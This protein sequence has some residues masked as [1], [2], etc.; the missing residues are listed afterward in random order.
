MAASHERDAYRVGERNLFA[1]FVVNGY[2]RGYRCVL[3]VDKHIVEANGGFRLVELCNLAGKTHTRGRIDRFIQEH[4]VGAGHEAGVV[5]DNLV[6]VGIDVSGWSFVPSHFC[7][8]TAREGILHL[9]VDKLLQVGGDELVF[10]QR[11]LH[12]DVHRIGG[13]HRNAGS[14]RDVGTAT[15]SIP[16]VGIS[17]ML[18]LQGHLHKVVGE[19][20]RRVG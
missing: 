10:R 14:K 2:L 18:A 13:M 19:V 7:N 4:V 1:V 8:L 11:P 9:L 16:K 12:G 5:E 17:M 6:V 20:E 3:A 15:E